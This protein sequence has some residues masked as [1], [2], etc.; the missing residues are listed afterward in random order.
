[1]KE[2]IG[3]KLGGRGKCRYCKEMHNNVAY[4][5][6]HACPKNPNSISSKTATIP[7]DRTKEP[8]QVSKPVLKKFLLDIADGF[9]KELFEKTQKQLEEYWFF[10][11]DPNALIEENLYQFHDMLKLYGSFCRRWE[12][13]HNGSCCVVERVRDKYLMPKI[14]LFIRDLTSSFILVRRNE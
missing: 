12:E 3:N 4:H 1:M 2:K 11:Y 8:M 5:E 6:S 7:L 13:H 14:R 10:K 9:N